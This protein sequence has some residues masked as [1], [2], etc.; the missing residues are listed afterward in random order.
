MA[1]R[2]RPWWQYLLLPF[3]VSGPLSVLILSAVVLAHLPW[4]A[5]LVVG[6]LCLLVLIVLFF[7]FGV[8]LWFKTF[9]ETKEPRH[10]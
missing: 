4:P 3:F 8:A 7:I 10:G 9:G 2:K 6:A 1:D 5:E